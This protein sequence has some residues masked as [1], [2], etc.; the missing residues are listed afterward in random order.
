MYPLTNEPQHSR[1]ALMKS[2]LC[3]LAL[4]L[5]FGSLCF[6]LSAVD[7]RGQDTVT[8]A[9]EGTVSN[10]QTGDVLKGALVEIINEQ[11]GVAIN[12]HSDYRGRFYQGLL[13]PGVYR[14][15]VSTAGYQTREVLQRLKITYTGEVV[16]VP[17]ALDP[18]SALPT[19]APAPAAV[20]D[21]EIRSLINTS[22]ARHSGSF[23][24]VELSALPL[25]SNSSR[26]KRLPRHA[27]AALA[28]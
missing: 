4:P 12:L 20:E 15:R 21:T 22:D 28:G 5:F 26:S 2:T 27:A 19:P 6:A 7:S 24:D 8:G 14:V 16:P 3:R 17:V 11:T 1:K 18:V 13:I 23:S 10:S 25:R 9:F